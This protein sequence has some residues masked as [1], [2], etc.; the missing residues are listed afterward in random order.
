MLQGQLARRDAQ[1]NRLNAELAAMREVEIEAREQH[2]R[3]CDC[4]GEACRLGAAL[5]VVARLRTRQRS[6]LSRLQGKAG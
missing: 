6:Q 5:V 2:E 3:E 4:I 1:I